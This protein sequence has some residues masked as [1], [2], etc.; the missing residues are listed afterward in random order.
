MHAKP[1][2][3]GRFKLLIEVFKFAFNESFFVEQKM[4]QYPRFCEISTRG[5][6]RSVFDTIRCDNRNDMDFFIVSE[7]AIDTILISCFGDRYEML[8]QRERD[9]AG[10]YHSKAERARE[11]ERT[12]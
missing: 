4:R 1:N 3:F 12:P 8:L 7:N 11:R 5:L 6:Y 9:V 10:K 2:L